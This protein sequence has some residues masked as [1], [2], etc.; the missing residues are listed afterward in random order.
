MTAIEIPEYVTRAKSLTDIT[1]IAT[2]LLK[3]AAD[4]G[5]PPPDMARLSHG[6]QEASL[7]FPGHRDTFRA[8]A[9]WAERFGGTVT[10][11]P[12]TNKDG[13]QSVYCQ[14]KFPHLGISVEAYAFITADH[15]SST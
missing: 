5:L 3:H 8:L 12:H 1:L 14:V 11:E 6:G 9:R 2:E 13:E 15:L 10:G 7:G 4:S